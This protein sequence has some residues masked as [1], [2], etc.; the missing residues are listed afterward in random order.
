MNLSK[1]MA[2]LLT[3]LL[4]TCS[5]M[6]GAGLASND[7]TREKQDGESNWWDD[8]NRDKNHNKIDDVIEE[9]APEEKIG[10]FIN[11]DR[12]PTKE[13]IN[14]L[15]KFDIDIKYVYKYIDVICARNVDFEDVMAVS[16]LPHVVMVKLETKVYPALD[17]S[18]R[19]IKTRES[20]NYSPTTA[21]EMGFTGAGVSIAILDTG[22]DDGG[23]APG[24]KHD[25]LDDLDDNPV[26]NEVSDRKR[27]AGVDFTQ[28]ETILVPRDGSYDP[29]DTYGHGT[30]CAGIALGTGGSDKQYIGMAPQAR[31]VDVKVIEN[32]GKG[33]TGDTMAGLEWCIDHMNEYN[34]K[35]LSLSL[36]G[37]QNSDGSDEESQMVNTAVDAGLVVVVSIGN[38]GDLPPQGDGV[39]DNSNLI[40]RPAAADKAITVGSVY[41]HETIDRSDDTLSDFSHTGPRLDDGDD[42]PYDELKPDV[43]AYG[44]DITSAQA[45]TAS[46]TITH[47]G[48]SMA[49]PHVAGVVALIL[50]A[51]PS[52]SPE[53]VK[54][55]LHD[56]AEQRGTPSFPSLDP[57]YNTH[58]GWGI[59][60]AYKAVELAR[61]F[62]DIGIDIN[63]PVEDTEVRGTVEISGNAYILM[64]SGSISSVEVS[65]D[66]PK[67]ETYTLTSEETTSW[68]V[69]WDTWGWNGRRTIYAKATSGQYTAI[70]SVD[71][72]VYNSGSSGGDDGLPSDEGPPKIDLP[73]GL[74]KV[75]LYAA[76]G[77]VLII[78]AIVGIIVA[79]V[80]LRRRRFYK[81]LLAARRAE[82][83]GEQDIR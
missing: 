56:S 41:D 26:T 54:K 74:G 23:W 43:V 42:D 3:I 82:Q 60:D 11:Y 29:D 21:F 80:I 37:S 73:F 81:Q 47:S 62:V 19:A 6:D 72:T 24:Q 8:W 14:R 52:L 53:N 38:D 64:G 7:N 44:E 36:G 69:S 59:V 67:F 57:K 34:I 55:I 25:F 49:C 30:H 32:W 61:G 70:T 18:A 13:D 66:D 33:N 28:E 5:F 1:N 46:G 63:H 16:R 40:S 51:N 9:I 48:T 68:S 75:S 35:I 12:H 39:A 31:L 22:V 20:D 83:G 15:S 58:Y 77:F 17:V 4:I 78:A 76:V 71:V 50:E 45:N 2:L 65:I 27:I 79:T 10:I